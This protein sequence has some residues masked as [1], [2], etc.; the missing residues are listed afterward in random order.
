[1]SIVPPAALHHT[2]FIV[3]DLEKAARA[4]SASLG[5]GPWN[6]YT[7]TPTECR[8]HGVASPFSFRVAL[9]AVGGGNYELVSPLTGTSVYNEHLDQHG[10]GFHHTCLFYPTIEA[11]RAAKAELVRQ[12]R[13]VIQE[14]SA[15]DAFEF[16]YI[17]FPEIGSVIEVLYLD[18]DQMP[19]PDMVI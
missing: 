13:E 15:G 17:M 11:V 2:A 18:G 19:S 3:R 14:A 4:L 7:I 12:G 5:I 8:V 1:M 9:T 10:E 16:A 6:V